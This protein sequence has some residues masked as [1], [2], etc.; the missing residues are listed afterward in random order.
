LL[1]EYPLY[2]YKLLNL[3]FPSFADQNVIYIPARDEV[4]HLLVYLLYTTR[5]FSPNVLLQTIIIDNQDELLDFSA[6]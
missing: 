4:N 2:G 5:E 1:R 3:N 6:V